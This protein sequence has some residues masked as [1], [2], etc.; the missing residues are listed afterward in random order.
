M[1]SSEICLCSYRKESVR[2][3]YQ[4]DLEANSCPWTW[5]SP[6]LWRVSGMEFEECPHSN[7]Q[8]CLWPEHTEGWGNHQLK[9]P[10]IYLSPYKNSS[11][12]GLP[13][14]LYDSR[15]MD[16]KWGLE[17]SER[18]SVH[19]G[20]KECVHNSQDPSQTFRH[21][22]CLALWSLIIRCFWEALAYLVLPYNFHL[23]RRV[24]NLFL[25]VQVIKLI[26]LLRLPLVLHRQVLTHVHQRNFIHF[27]I[28]E[29]NS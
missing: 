14:V 25:Q 22:N 27:P 9:D 10:D 3:W 24:T 18:E 2:C 21:S 19:W 1:T 26:N 12:E 29:P 17:V 28:E 11:L 16:Q 8:R 7:S 15:R 20:N 5:L 13:F 6:V 23:C 4:K